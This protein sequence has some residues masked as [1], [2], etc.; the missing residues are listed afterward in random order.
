MVTH[1]VEVR[2]P[3]QEIDRKWRNRW[4]Q[5]KLYKVSDVDHRPK[6]YE[7]TM[8]PY[9]SGDLHIGHWYAMAPAD[10]HARFR[11][12]QGYNVLHPMGFDAF[13]L[14]AENAAIRRGIHP[15]EWTIGN[16]ETMRAQLQSMG[17]IYDWDR[18]IICCLPEYYR[19]TQWLFLQLYKN[20]LAYRGR[21]PVVWCPSCQTVLAN[22]QVLNG[23][24]E[25]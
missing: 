22:E 17:T 23:V 10:C 12:M 6:W 3:A 7:L 24:C 19:W 2:F 13:G 16:I 5:D 25:R 11:R 14:P 15:S 9:P 20:G 1:R 8:Y 21:A 18:E 4:A